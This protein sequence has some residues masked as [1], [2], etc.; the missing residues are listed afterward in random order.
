MNY[1]ALV[2]G[3]QREKAAVRIYRET[4]SIEAVARI[5]HVSHAT[6]RAVVSVDPQ[7]TYCCRCGHTLEAGRKQTT[8]YMCNWHWSEACPGKVTAGVRLPMCRGQVCIECG[9]EIKEANG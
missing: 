2:A 3:I 6:A 5:M 8:C 4:G 1:A 7:T 9:E